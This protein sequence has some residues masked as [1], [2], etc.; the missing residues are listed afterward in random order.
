MLWQP[1]PEAELW[2]V[3]QSYLSIAFLAASQ[4]GFVV[5]VLPE[6]NVAELNTQRLPLMQLQVT[7]HGQL[8]HVAL[9]VPSLS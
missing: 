7:Q 1:A 4:S 5:D 2:S 8:V 9:S 3:C 6:F